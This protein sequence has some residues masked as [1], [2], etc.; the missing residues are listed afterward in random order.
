MLQLG[1]I[2]LYSVRIIP[3]V[4]AKHDQQLHQVKLQEYKMGVL[5]TTA[6]QVEAS[7]LKCTSKTYPNPLPVFVFFQLDLMM[8]NHF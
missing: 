5:L 3:H 1:N 2:K 8:A 7:D 4:S 6:S